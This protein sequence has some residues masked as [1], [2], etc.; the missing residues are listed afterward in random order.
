M[1]SILQALR[2][3]GVGGGGNIG[4]GGSI[5]PSPGQMVYGQLQT[6]PFTPA[7]TTNNPNVNY[8]ELL[9]RI[10]THSQQPP[11]IY[12]PYHPQ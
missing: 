6:T 3:A 8:S 11:N 10:Q 5:A 7:Q 1:A 12:T 4:V 9:Q 2:T